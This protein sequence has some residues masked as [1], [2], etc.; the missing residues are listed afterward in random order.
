MATV[1]PALFLFL[2]LAVTAFA[3]RRLPT[4]TYVLAVAVT[5]PAAFHK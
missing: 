5:D 4:A 2:A 3:L 1:L